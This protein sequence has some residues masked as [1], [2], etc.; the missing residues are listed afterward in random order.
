[1]I[2][3]LNKTKI[4][5]LINTGINFEPKKEYSD[6]EAF[7]LLDKVYER[8]VF[9]VQDGNSQKADAYADLADKIQEQIP[10]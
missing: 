6:D 7:D 10:D 5:L 3:I 4:A 1:M 8:E 9:F 2:I